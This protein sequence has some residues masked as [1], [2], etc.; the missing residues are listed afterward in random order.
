MV[1]TAPTTGVPAIHAAGIPAIAEARTWT[2]CAGAGH[3]SAAA[4][5]T[6]TS[7]PIPIP[8][9]L[10]GESTA[11]EGAAALRAEPVATSAAPALSRSR[12]PGRRR[13]TARRMAVRP[14]VAPE[15]ARSWP[16]P[17]VETPNSRATSGGTGESTSSAAWEVKRHRKTRG[18]V[19]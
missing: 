11:N 16:A 8:S 1:A 5:P 12:S 18:W 2:R 3:A 4:M 7:R 13:A 19:G 17:A 9:T 14:P 10:G 6:A 15:M